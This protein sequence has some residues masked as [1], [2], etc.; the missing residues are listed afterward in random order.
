MKKLLLAIAAIAAVSFVSCDTKTATDNNQATDSVFTIE[1]FTEAIPTLQD[2]AAVADLMAKANDQV[3][4]FLAAGDTVQ[5]LDLVGKIKEVIETN[6]DKLV[7]LV[8]T[9]TEFAGNAINLPEDL[10]A[11][12][13]ESLGD[14]AKEAVDNV[15]DAA[16]AQV[17]KAVDQAKEKANEAVDQAKEKA[18]EG[19]DKAK[20]KAADVAN[21]AA[22]ALKK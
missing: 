14:V 1:K 5:A 9:I 19:V 12:V 3:Q 15:T 13:N 8:P 20:E 17:D 18:A 2:S 21:K 10:K 7:A 16:A 22:E 11:K 4:K 6:K